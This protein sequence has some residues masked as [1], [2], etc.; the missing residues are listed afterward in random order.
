[1]ELLSK[2]HVTYAQTNKQSEISLIF[3]TQNSLLSLIEDGKTVVRSRALRGILL[4][5]L[6]KT[7]DNF[8][9]RL[10]ISEK[11]VYV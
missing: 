3:S 9:H 7:F 4:I 10:V 1:M 5:D 11:I 2:T 6:L 8:S